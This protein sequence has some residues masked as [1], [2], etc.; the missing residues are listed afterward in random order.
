MEQADQIA[1]AFPY[2]LEVGTGLRDFDAF[3]GGDPRVGG[4]TELDQGACGEVVDACG[5]GHFDRG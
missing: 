3:V 4:S 5:G 1:P 2:G